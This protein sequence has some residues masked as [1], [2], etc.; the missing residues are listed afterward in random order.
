MDQF[1]EKKIHITHTR[2]NNLNRPVSIKEINQ[3][4]IIFQGKKHQTQTVLLVN[5]IKHL[6]NYTNSPQSVP[7][8]RSRG[9]KS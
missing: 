5:S 2:K 1:F 6:R 3:Q 8:N 7:E 9:N 4:L